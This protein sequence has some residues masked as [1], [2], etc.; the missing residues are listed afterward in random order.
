MRS[1][2]KVV[3]IVLLVLNF[4]VSA[5]SQEKVVLTLEKSIEMALSQNPYHLAAAERVDGAQSMVR[6]A[7][8]GFLPKLNSRGTITLDEKLFQLEFPSFVPGEP[9]TRVEVDFTRDYQFALDLTVPLFTGGRLK[10][11][12]KQANYNLKS[13]EEYVRQ[14]ENVTVFNTKRA[15]YGCL[16]AKEFVRVAEL[17]LKDAEDLHKNIKSQYEVGIASQFDLLRSE[18]RVVNLKPQLIQAKNS[19]ETAKLNLKTLLGMDISVPI[20]VKGNL[21][22]KPISPELEES[23]I[24]AL[25]NRP[26]I[27][28]LMYQRKI[29]EEMKKIARAEKLPTLA[30]SGTFNY[31]GDQFS[32]KRENWQDYYSINL[33]LSW[34][35]F[36]GFGPSARMAQAESSLREIDLTM[37]GLRDS[38]EFDV[39]QSVL[40]IEETKETLLSQEKNVEQAEEALRIANLNFAEGMITVLD[41]SSAQTALTQARVNYSLALHDYFIALADYERALGGR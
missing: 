7:V 21:V 9:P 37:K 23:V 10:S 27:N 3:L 2:I 11:G 25:Q 34:S 1:G 24:M 18:V 6:E 32:F 13:T 33:V 20:E 35:L 36:N 16:L 29:T 4:G 8:S 22:Y 28:Q 19:F 41:V 5:F 39:N 31:W 12:L 38:V 30:L 15:F 17:A 14:S 26:E 40:K